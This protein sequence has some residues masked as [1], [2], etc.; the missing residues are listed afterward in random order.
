MSEEK[1][2]ISTS[3]IFLSSGGVQQIPPLVSTLQLEL[4]S[5][6]GHCLKVEVTMGTQG[7]DQGT[8]L[9]EEAAASSLC[10]FG[11]AAQK[12]ERNTHRCGISWQFRPLDG[13][14]YLNSP[15]SKPGAPKMQIHRK[16]LKLDV[17]STS[18]KRSQKSQTSRGCRLCA[19]H[20]EGTWEKC[21]TNNFPTAFLGVSA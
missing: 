1:A 20:A 14:E 2:Q 21:R 9:L 7:T 11:K 10:V 12:G 16:I 8:A 6:K 18:Y 4:H 5:L 3:L 13:R 15:V 17:T 19:P